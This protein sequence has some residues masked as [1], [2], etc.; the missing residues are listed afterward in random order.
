MQ[1]DNK[2]RKE[3]DSLI[4]EEAIRMIEEN[5]EEESKKTTV[6]YS[7]TWHKGVIGIVASRLLDRFYKPTIVFTK[8]GDVIAG[9]ARSIPGFNIHEGLEECKD[10]LIGFGGHYFAA[11][12]T[13]APENIEQFKKKFDEAVSSKLTPDDFIPVINIDAE[14]TLGELT[15]SFFSIQEQ[16]EPFG[17]ENLKPVFCVRNVN[18]IGCK[19]VKENHVRFVVEQDGII[20]NGIGFNLAEKYLAIPKEDTLDLVFTLDENTFNQQ[21]S[22]QLKVTDLAS[23]YAKK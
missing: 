4:T 10:L 12:M 1:S 22:L 19:I 6:L 17:P 18:N 23:S 11:G 5:P 8:S 14:V 7:P 2:S 9:S 21:T 3:T 20:F 15:P 13:M 16:M